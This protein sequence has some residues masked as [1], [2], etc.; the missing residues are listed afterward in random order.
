M[1]ERVVVAVVQQRCNGTREENLARSAEG[2]AEA[3]RRGAGLVL[4][5]ELHALPY[6][7][8][9]MDTQYFALAEPI[10]G[11][12]VS[13][14]G[15]L[16]RKHNIYIV[17]S[18]FERRGAGVYHNTAVVLGPEGRL[19]GMYRK[20]HIPDDPGFCE[21]FYFTPGDIGFT[22]I[23]TP[24]LTLGVQV[25]WDQ[26]YPEGARL[27]ALAG[28][29]VLLYPTAIGWVPEEPKEEQVRQREAWIIM[30]RA[31][32][33]ANALPVLV[34]NRVGWESNPQRP[35]T[36]IQFW[37]TSCILGAQGEVLAQAD[38]ESETVLTVEIDPTRTEAL[39]R[40]WP[41]LRDRR[42]DAYQ[43]LL[44]RFLH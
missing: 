15:D 1:S 43:G 7:C 13:Q 2:I 9:V 20:M 29:Q 14:L 36:G 24:R 23:A 3:A 18:I 16:A 4:L 44:E 39:R 32:A 34:A 42:I 17:G 21:K 19:L 8:Q 38:S 27:M 22:P 41:F 12:T 11:P 6:F 40:I 30:H 37:G 28:A 10:S 26:W 33:V 5:P 25:C 31:H 35:E